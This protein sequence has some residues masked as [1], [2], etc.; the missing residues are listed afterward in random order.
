MSLLK[1]EDAR[2]WI[3]FFVAVLSIIGGYTM[4]AF[5]GQLGEWFD[6]EARIQYFA[7]MGQGVG[8]LSGLIIFV[9]LTRKKSTLAHMQE[10]YDELLKVIWPNRDVVVK[11]TIGIVIGVSILSS[12]FVA[13]DF[14]FNK[15]LD[16]VY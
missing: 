3:N 6:L 2:K 5:I 10:V 9:V 11:V 1:S 15:F 12:I 13:V 8:I 14:L 4:I 7:M 16:L